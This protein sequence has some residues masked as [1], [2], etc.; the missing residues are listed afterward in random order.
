MKAYIIT[1]PI[2]Y[3]GHLE[4]VHRILRKTR[5]KQTIIDNRDSI[6]QNVF[7]LNIMHYIRLK[8]AVSGVVPCGTFLIAAPSTLLG[9]PGVGK[10]G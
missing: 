8:E 2:Y 1:H 6:S 10:W 9:E 5:H 3:I 7:S 4:I